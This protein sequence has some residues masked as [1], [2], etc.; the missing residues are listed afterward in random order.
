MVQIVITYV[1]GIQK[2]KN[3][4]DVIESHSEM[5]TN[6]GKCAGEWHPANAIRQKPY[7]RACVHI[8]A[9]VTF[10]Y[11]EKIPDIKRRHS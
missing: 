3:E 2:E 9:H 4:Y 7:S 10:K 1:G 11:R 5:Q 8:G 6:I